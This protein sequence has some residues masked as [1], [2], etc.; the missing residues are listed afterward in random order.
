LAEWLIEQGIG[1]NRA[2]L[3]D[4]GEIL[5]AR[6]DWPGCLSAGLVAD[7]VLISRHAGSKRGIARFPGGEE[8]LVDQL[9]RDA[10]EGAALR[11]IVTRAAMAETGRYKLAQSRPTQESTRPAPTLAEQLDGRVV[12]RFPARLWEDVFAEA[13]TRT[14]DFAGG[15]LTL[16]P[17]PAMTVIDV[18][19]GLPSPALARAAAVAVADTV[20]RLDLAGSIGID[21]PTL[22]DK[23]DRRA[24]DQALDTALNHWPHERTS[25]NGF[26]FVQ[27]VARLERPSLLGRLAHD[28]AGAAA[29]LLL[30]Q[31]EGVEQ[32]GAILLTCHPLVRAA[33]DPAWEAALAQR[34]AREIRWQIDSTLALGSGFAQ[35]VP[36]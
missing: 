1:E 35:A 8:A 16:S 17:T 10:A 25:M 7:A 28:R 30:R 22:A 13:W 11:L 3:L 18:D 21:F 5:A 6:L 9:P 29:R 34:T 26:G 31:A 19:G 14:V 2:I 23:A 27:I 15:S 12:R 24:V 36:R 20:G 33:I 32:P 4:G